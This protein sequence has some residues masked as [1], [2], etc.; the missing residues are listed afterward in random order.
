M[1]SE[2]RS[3]YRIRSKRKGKTVTFQGRERSTVVSLVLDVKL[4]SLIIFVG[5][6][7]RVTHGK[8]TTFMK[9]SSQMMMGS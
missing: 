4:V 6:L 5:D 9:M 8:M 2:E 3:D 1:G 7:E